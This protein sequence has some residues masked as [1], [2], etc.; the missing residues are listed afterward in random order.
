VLTDPD[1]AAWLAL[2]PC[3]A[4]TALVVYAFGPALGDIVYPA[5]NP[6]V[7]WEIFR[8][9]IRPEPTEQAR[10]LLLLGGPLLLAAA[11]ATTVWR[12]PRV[13]AR[14]VA[15]G[16]PLAQAA[17]VGFVALCMATQ[18]RYEY[19]PIWS[20]Q[21][22]V[23][24]Q[25]MYFN[26]RT[27]VVA[28]VVMAAIVMAARS[29]RFRGRFGHWTRDTF[30][31]RL[32]ALL[33]AGA[34][35]VV[36]LLQG[37]NSDTSIATAIGAV[38]YHVEF[39]LDE[40]F[41]VLNGL[42][43]L[44]DFTAQ[45]GSL[46]PLAVAASMSLFGKTLLVFTL[47]MSGITVV[48]MLAVYDLLRRVARSAA[49]GLLLYLPFLATSF[50]LIRGT[51]VNRYSM[52]TYYGAFPLRYAGP[53]LV[54]WVTTRRLQRG[55]GRYDWALFALAGIVVLNNAD[56]G[57]AAFGAS[58]AAILWTS[59]RPRPWPLLRLG[60][61]IAGGVAISLG[62]VTVLALVR[63]GTLPQFG[64]LLE[65]AAIYTRGSFAMLP[66][67]GALGVHTIIYVTYVAAIAT[68]TVRALARDDDR[69]TTGMLVWS[70][71][72]GLGAA[73]YYMGRSHP[74]SLVSTF[75][76]WALALALLTVVTVRGMIAHAGRRPA[77]ASLL[78]LFGFG[79][80]VCSL[81]QTPTPWT[82]LQRLDG[83]HGTRD[84]F[85]R[86]QRQPFVPVASQRLFFSST[87]YGDKMYVKEGTPVANLTTG[88]HRISEAF[89]VRNVA[90]YTGTSVAGPEMLKTVIE[91]LRDAGGNTLFIVG[92][93]QD[94]AN[95]LVDEGFVPLGRRGWI[96]LDRERAR[97]DLA[98]VRWTYARVT[99]WVDTFNSAP[100]YLE[101]DRGR[102]VPLVY[103]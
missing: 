22:G 92:P 10:Y 31:W 87:R 86:G 45:Y 55:E 12:A 56:F 69:L 48:S 96:E 84:V 88:G 2:L 32:G 52:A 61:H 73:A 54:A 16:V 93:S 95:V 19:G 70:G 4:V 67:P 5:H 66:V 13:P 103:R 33:L 40:T 100:A 64:R 89:G 8:T 59:G 57:V 29:E 82:Q 68:G 75:S 36:W 18:Y 27:L 7:F 71:V 41:A 37:I 53:F 50:F 74:E 81:A 26:P 3:A 44:V 25:R 51:F 20:F 77:L 46:W 21:P 34:A 76:A 72:F 90:R 15:I 101:H 11:T 28:M 94:E 83:Q 79:V 47:V 58:M 85:L 1:V 91:D 49:L 65:Y 62:L 39:T 60:A 63:A 9:N 102:P 97:P 30:A 80:A 43:P 78:V 35:T 98:G 17:V 42:T 6:Y 23:S 99:K 38:T 14:L 24:F